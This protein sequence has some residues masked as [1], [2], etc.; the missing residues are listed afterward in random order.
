LFTLLVPLALWGRPRG[1]GAPRIPELKRP[2]LETELSPPTSAEVKNMW[3]Y[4][5]TVHGVVFS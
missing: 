3:N 4:E 5:R 1:G 2:E